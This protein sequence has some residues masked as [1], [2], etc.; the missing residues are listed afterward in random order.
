MMALLKK[1]YEKIVLAIGLLVL[2]S[3]AAFLAFKV[4]SLSQEIQ[5]APHR[6]VPKAKGI[7]TLDLG[8]YS[9]AMAA[10]AQPPLW[11]TEPKLFPPDVP[12]Q[13]RGP[14]I[15]TNQVTGNVPILL[16]VQHQPFKLLFMQYSGEG[17]NFQLNFLTRARTFFVSNIG[18]PIKDQFGDTG[19][20]IT[21]FEK[22]KIM[23]DDA[24]LGRKRENDIS[25]LTIQHEGEDLIVLVVGQITEQREPVAI[26]LCKGSQRPQQVVRQQ[27]FDCAGKTYIVVDITPNQMI[28]IDAQSG[29]RHTVPLGAP[30]E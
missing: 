2:I 30:K 22:K 20:R 3:S 4:G 27:Q 9:N 26:I 19:Y 1:H 13:M 8:T 15:T 7:Q 16:Q 24:S 12:I 29:E 25:E 5:E 23:V 11:T 14:D 17:Q 10:L 21:K 6:I 28:I 18:D